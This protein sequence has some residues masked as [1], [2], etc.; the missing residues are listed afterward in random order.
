MNTMMAKQPQAKLYIILGGG[1]VGC[2]LAYKL[3]S[4]EHAHVAM[5]EGRL[6]D[7]PQVVR[8]PFAIAKD[9]PV[10]VQ[11]KMWSDP[12]TRSRIF[13]SHAIDA[14]DFWPKPGY[15]YWPW[16]S[17]GCFQQAMVELL[18]GDSRYKDRFYFIPHAHEVEQLDLLPAIKAYYPA[19]ELPASMAICCTCGNYAS[20]FR[21]Q[22]GLQA[23]K[24][25]EPKGHGI[26]LIY[27]NAEVESYW[28]DEQPISYLS[29]AEQGISYAA[30]NNTKLDVQLYTYPAGRLTEIF[31]HMPASFMEHSQ[32]RPLP[33]ALDL[34]G[35]GL[36][37]DAMLWFEQYK[38]LV[39]EQLQQYK[40]QFPCDLSEIKVFYAARTEY[41]W[42]VVA[43]NSLS[44]ANCPLFFVG[45]SAGSTDYKFGLSVG[46][47]FL[48]ASYLAQACKLPDM[49][50][51][52]AQYQ[53]YWDKVVANEFNKGPTLTAEPWI[54]Y[55]YLVK[56]REVVYRD[57]QTF[58]YETEQDFALYLDDYQCLVP[59]YV[60]SSQASAVVY[61]NTHAVQ[62]NIAKVSVLA[63][64]LGDS[65]VVAV[66]KGNGYGLGAKLM[67]ELAVKA[68]VDFLGV[69]KLNEAIALREAGFAPPIRIMVF[70]P[71]L[72]HDLSC[73]HKYDIEL[74]LPSSQH[75]ESVAMLGK[76]LH[77]RRLQT[78]SS[79]KVHVMVDTGLRR[80]GGA[81]NNIP[82]AVWQTLAAIQ[83]FPG[84][85]IVLA[86]IA[87]HLACYRCTDYNGEEVVDYRALQL[88]RLHAA[89]DYVLAKGIEIPML[90]VG[91]GLGL[92]AEQWP[93]HFAAIARLH[94]IQLYTRVGHGIYGME[95]AEELNATSPQLA[96]TV[97]LNL[98]VRNIFH[99]EEGEPVSYGGHWRAPK[100]GVWIATLSGGW[101]DGVPRTAK[102]LGLWDKGMVVD[103]NGQHYPVVGAI[104]M[105]AMMV[106]LGVDTQVQ[107]G[108]RA[109]VFGWKAHQ[110][111]LR[112]LA[113]LSGQ[114]NPSITVNIPEQIPRIAVSA[115]D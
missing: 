83:Q 32:Y 106:N 81:L 53:A 73:Y 62:R 5:F 96:C 17:I 94:R 101:N 69:A 10:A 29:L 3:L 103:I 56:G 80:D 95:L 45:D 22:A 105:N 60:T 100:D 43:T 6:F 27:Q 76:W 34:T 2:Y 21:Q 92:L 12:E 18:Q 19:A 75:G 28:R 15:R 67:A 64:S 54:Q 39:V 108:D 7:R 102:T 35:K 40:L 49:A 4:Q 66:V 9:L 74:M 30:A 11:L 51:V 110:P 109:I 8:I 55:Q 90:H 93:R 20:L 24:Q 59:G 89:L 57:G 104:N 16:L 70:E 71:P 26:Y 58:R 82:Q 52:M 50:Q 107:A 113:A 68:G 1:P 33:Q 31:A 115:I 37:S 46:R 72:L 84:E 25:P 88:Q 78:A 114:I 13:S 42:N 77:S 38:T 47:G 36:P 112:Q 14:S 97:E 61:I 87:T 48:A 111:Q 23:G 44:Y 65:K 85:D 99:V 79:L 63:R 86:G 91:G 41:Y 98:Q